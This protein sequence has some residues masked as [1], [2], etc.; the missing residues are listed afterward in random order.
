MRLTAL[1]QQ[2]PHVEIGAPHLGDKN[3]LLSERTW[4]FIDRFDTYKTEEATH[5]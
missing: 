3:L 2:Q 1:I 5:Y 4:R